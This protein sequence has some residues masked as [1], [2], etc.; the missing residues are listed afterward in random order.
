M[1]QSEIASFRKSRFASVFLL[2]IGLLVTSVGLTY[3]LGLEAN[4]SSHRLTEL[5]LAIEC[6]EQLQGSV[7]EAETGQRGFLLVGKE[8]YLDPYHAALAAIEKELAS[9]DDMAGRGELAKEDVDHVK[10]LTRQ[11]LA[12]LAQTIADYRKRGPEAALAAVL[13]DRGQRVM[14]QLRRTVSDLTSA[15]EDKYRQAAAAA[16]RATTIRTVVFLVTVFG[17]LALLIWA[18]QRI[19]D[20]VRV[21]EALT[22][23]E[24]RF[25]LL[26]QQA[27]IGI[28]RLD[29]AEERMLD[30]NDRLCE[31]LGYSRQELL[32]M[33]LADFTHPGDLDVERKELARLAGGKIPFFTIEKRCLR[34][35]RGVI[36]VRVTNSLP[37][38][39]AGAP[40]GNAGAKWWISVV[41]DITERKRADEA[42]FRTT[43]ELKRSNEDLEQFAYAASHDLQEPLRMVAGYLQLLRERYQGRLDEKADKFITYAVDGAERMSS[44]VHDLLAYA[45]V[46]SRGERFEKTSAEDALCFALKNLS[47]AVMDS[48]AS[49]QHDPLPTVRADRTQLRQLFQN[50]IGNAVKFRDPGRSARINVSAREDDDYWHF[51]VKD[52]GIGFDDKYRDKMF[53]IFQ[54]LQGR[55][56]YPGTGIGL[57]ICKRIVERHGGEIWAT[58]QPGEGSTFHFTIPIEGAA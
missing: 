34:K 11:K 12:E 19:G 28:K 25:R 23:S 37:S 42:L 39:F 3:W 4:E 31:I 30:V 44:L 38:H 40:A 15:E 50:L 27:A 13:S 16:G 6:L 33:S 32:Q 35:D 10:S 46:N 14:D 56:K 22:E 20:T 29:L 47:S 36:W 58:G 2:V 8:S 57:A 7:T 52:N 51:V 1:R 55:G 48:G 24:E 17:N 49:V 43:A 53:L 45:R 9:L 21:E 26:F 18:Y 5:R 54:R 41:E